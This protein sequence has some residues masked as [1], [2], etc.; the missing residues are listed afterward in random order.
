MVRS[1]RNAQL[2]TRTARLKPPVAKK[3]KFVRIG[4]GISVGYR[5]NKAAG[6]WVLR[7][8]DGRGG[9]STKTIGMADDY[10]EADGVTALDFWQAQESA[11]KEARR[12]RGLPCGGG[13]TVATATDNYVSWLKGKNVRTAAD[14]KGRL[15]KHFLPYFGNIPITAL[16]KT[17]LDR[18][19]SSLVVHQTDQEKARR[20]KDSANRVL[21]MV[22]ALL[23]HAMREQSNGITDD[24]GWRL[25]RPFA[26]VS[27][28][29]DIR[30]TDDQVIRLIKC[31]PD[32]ATSN[33]ITGAFLTGARY[34]ELTNVTVNDLDPSGQ[35]LNIRFGKTGRRA[36]VLQKSAFDFLRRLAHGKEADEPL[37]VRENGCPW[38]RSDQIRPI[39]K[40]LK[41]AGLSPQG[42]LYA[43]RHTYISSAIEGG[44]PLNVVAKNCGTSIRMIEKTY[45]KLLTE[46]TRIFIENGAPKLP[47][48][49]W[50]RRA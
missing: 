6:T 33:L 47:E 28:P 12:G 25:V 16:T 32:Q 26:G 23:N 17:A 42:T 11:K 5:R 3:P 46:K 1:V 45:A 29:R 18:W 8:A 38:K 49:A 39:K 7:V 14:T 24:S 9:S 48:D 4:S 31:A 43:L 19:L 2:E 34:G 36:I 35:I 30:F 20:S 50:S 40:S 37:F 10:V 41:T 21:S 44:V 13:I 15:E 22:K 27:K